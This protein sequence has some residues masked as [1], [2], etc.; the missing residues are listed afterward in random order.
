ME[1]IA[2]TIATQVEAEGFCRPETLLFT[3]SSESLEGFEQR[4]FLSLLSHRIVQEVK[5][6][7][8]EFDLSLY[9]SVAGS[10][11]PKWL[12]DVKRYL[13]KY[14]KRSGIPLTDSWVY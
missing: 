6:D 10:L 2:I 4:I 5:K 1:T 12:L 14:F 7:I 8:F 11:D 13:K 9:V 3:R